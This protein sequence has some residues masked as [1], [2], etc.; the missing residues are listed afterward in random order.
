MRNNDPYLGMSSIEIIEQNDRPG[1]EIAHQPLNVDIIEITS[2]NEDLTPAKAA[3][4]YTYPSSPRACHKSSPLRTSVYNSEPLDHSVELS[5]AFHDDTTIG[6]TISES[7]FA[8]L[9]RQQN[10]AANKSKESS[11]ASLISLNKSG[12][13][14]IDVPKKLESALDQI[15]SEDIFSSDATE[16]MSRLAPG[17][18]APLSLKAMGHKWSLRDGEKLCFSESEQNE[19][20]KVAEVPS[21]RNLFVKSSQS[22]AS[23]ALPHDDRGQSFIE[24]EQCSSSTRSRSISTDNKAPA[25]VIYQMNDAIEHSSTPEPAKSHALDQN[26]V[27]PPNSTAKVSLKYSKKRSHD[28]TSEALLSKVGDRNARQIQ[29]FVVLGRSFT[30]EESKLEINK[31]LATGAGKKEFNAANKLVKEPSVLKEEISIDINESLYQ[32]FLEDGVDL[33][34]RLSPAQILHTHTVNPLMKLRRNCKS[35]Y[36]YEHG[37]FYPIKETLVSES[38]S[39][40][41]YDALE[42]FHQYTVDKLRLKKFIEGCKEGGQLVLIMVNGCDSLIKGLQNLENRRFRQQINEELGGASPKRKR[43]NNKNFSKLE[44]LN[45][46]PTDVEK[47][48]ESIAILMKVH[49]FSVETKQDFAVWMNNLLVV[50]GRKRYDPIIRHQ[51]WSHISLRSAHDPQDALSKTVEQLDQMTRLKA[52][53]VVA[54][55]KSFQQLYEDVNKGYLISGNDGNSLMGG[56]AEKAMATLLTSENPEELIYLD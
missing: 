29:K 1:S 56:A 31:N 5:A 43:G 30:D 52:Q 19:A 48:I 35:I 8:P 40:L 4:R 47:E 38:I 26:L 27:R 44:E 9:E 22:E 13:T 45:I 25:S 36:D 39:I 10:A 17:E 2:G 18:Q 23:I 32:S 50:V 37:I 41:Y 49:F 46:K 7:S 6:E 51:D 15:I 24:E 16:N 14:G 28:E 54:V 12:P 11:P 3:T 42:F 20:E 33:R 53:R 55:Y 21:A 34:E